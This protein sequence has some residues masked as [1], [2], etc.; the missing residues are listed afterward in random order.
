MVNNLPGCQTQ[1]NTGQE[2]FEMVNDAV[3]TYLDVP[4]QYVPF[5]PAFFPP[6]ETR[7][8]MGIEIPQQYLSKQLVFE[9]K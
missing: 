2:L 9:R 7:Q 6:E 8:K 3:Y 5:L 4:S 1:A